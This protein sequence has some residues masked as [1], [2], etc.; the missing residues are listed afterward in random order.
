[1]ATLQKIVK[2]TQSQYNTLKNGGTVKGETGLN[3]EW[4]YLV[5]DSS[6]GGW[7]YLGDIISY[8]G[9]LDNWEPTFDPRQMQNKMVMLSFS[10]ADKGTMESYGTHIFY[11]G[12]TN[13]N[14]VTTLHV[15]SQFMHGDV[16]IEGLRISFA[17]GYGFYYLDGLVSF[18]RGMTSSGFTP[19]AASTDEWQDFWNRFGLRMSVFVQDVN[20]L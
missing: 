15:P 13:T 10:A 18:P 20:G 14:F 4:L 17:S 7:T 8:G 9:S 3:D 2:L 19:T 5:P 1:M 11:M 6:S 12:S 16:S